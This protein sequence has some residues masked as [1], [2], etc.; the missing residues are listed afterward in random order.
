L[1]FL[2]GS[3]H[4]IRSR[5]ILF[6]S[7]STTWIIKLLKRLRKAWKSA[8]LR[9]KRRIRNHQR[10]CKIAGNSVRLTTF[11]YMYTACKESMLSNTGGRKSPGHNFESYCERSENLL[12]RFA[13]GDCFQPFMT[14]DARTYTAK[15]W[16]CR[17]RVV[18]PK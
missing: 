6:S 15:N 2:C 8:Y 7:L 3:T 1:C 5:Q 4:L 9:V 11:C 14:H 12:K 18:S 13:L 17:E 10:Y 16:S